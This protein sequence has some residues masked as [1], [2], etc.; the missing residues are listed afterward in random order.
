MRIEILISTTSN[1]AHEVK[2][3][4][5]SIAYTNTVNSYMGTHK[6]ETAPGAW[7]TSQI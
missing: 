6:T 5:P 1:I 7:P 3:Q 4:G 2:L